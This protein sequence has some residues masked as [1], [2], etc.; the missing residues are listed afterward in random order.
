[1][2]IQRILSVPDIRR[3]FSEFIP[4]DLFWVSIVSKSHAKEFQD[5]LLCGSIY[6]SIT[7]KRRIRSI[8]NSKMSVFLLC[9]SSINTDN[10][11]VFNW[12]LDYEPLVRNQY[13]AEYCIKENNTAFLDIMLRHCACNLDKCMLVKYASKIDGY[14]TLIYFHKCGFDIYNL[15]YIYKYGNL[16]V[17][18]YLY[19]N[20]IYFDESNISELA[21]KYGHLHILEWIYENRIYWDEESVLNAIEFNHLDIL[22]WLLDHGCT[23][24]RRSIYHMYDGSKQMYWNKVFGILT[25]YGVFGVL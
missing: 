21:S 1:M 16:P 20:M 10:Y 18:E 12:C 17:I 15:L 24:S 19:K 9:L 14:D 2:N 25:R 8:Y 5:K 3:I 6:R 23:V 7:S 13:V 4:N 11:E 22:E